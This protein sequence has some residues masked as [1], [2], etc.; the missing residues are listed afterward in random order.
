MYY[1]GGHQFLFNNQE[2]QINQ[3]KHMISNNHNNDKNETN[4]N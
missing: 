2:H 1:S 4:H 3:V